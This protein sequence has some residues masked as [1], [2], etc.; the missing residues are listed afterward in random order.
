MARCTH[1]LGLLEMV[2]GASRSPSL[3][4]EACIVRRSGFHNL[5][6]DS[7]ELAVVAAAIPKVRVLKKLVFVIFKRWRVALGKADESRVFCSILVGLKLRSEV[8]DIL[9]GKVNLK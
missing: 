7:S 3:F 5:F 6:D 1:S 2:R 4:L 9:V 8:A